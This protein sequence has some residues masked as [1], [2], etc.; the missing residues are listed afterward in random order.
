MLNA[1]EPTPKVDGC[2]SFFDL[3]RNSERTPKSPTFPQILD[4]SAPNP[5]PFPQILDLSANAHDGW[6]HV[7]QS[8]GQKAIHEQNKLPKSST[9]Q[10]LY[11]Q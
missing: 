2:Q 7:N 9:F 11:E 10:S 1:L 8:L 3:S 5:R 6:P 4:L